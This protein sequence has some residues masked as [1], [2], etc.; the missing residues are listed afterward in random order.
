M[1]WTPEMKKCFDNVIR[2]YGFNIYYLKIALP[3]L[4][5]KQLYNHWDKIQGKL[6]NAYHSLTK[7]DDL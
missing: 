2:Q 4:N 3:Y 1:V 5:D 7:Y 6:N